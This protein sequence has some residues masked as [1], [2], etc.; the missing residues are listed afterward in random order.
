MRNRLPRE[1]VSRR[2][3]RPAGPV[4]GSNSKSDAA[5]HGEAN[6]NASERGMN[7]PAKTSC[8]GEAAAQPNV[9]AM[10][11]LGL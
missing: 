9:V 6:S 1:F 11:V 2:L 8:W 5:N 3:R 7:A 4:G 10:M